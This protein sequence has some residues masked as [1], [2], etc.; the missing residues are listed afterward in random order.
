MKFGVIIH[1]G[2]HTLSGKEISWSMSNAKKYSS[3]NKKWDPKNWNPDNWGD[4][5]N[6]LGAKY[7]VWVA[8][9]HDGFCEW[10]TQTTNYN[11]MHTPY[12]KDVTAEIAKM[13]RKYGIDLGLYL[14]IMDAH[15]SGWNRIYPHGT[16]MPGF[17]QE[18][19][20]LA[21]YVKRQGLELIHKYHPFELWFDG[22]WLDGWR[23]SKYPKG[24]ATTFRNADSAILM[25][26]LGNYVNDYGSMEAKVG[27]Y[28]P[29]PWETVTSVSYPRYSWGWNLHFKSVPYLVQSFC[30]T[31]IGNGNYLL[32]FVPAPSGKIQEKQQKIAKKMGTWVHKNSTAIFGTRA[33]PYYPNKWGGSTHRG[34]EVY[35]FI[36]KEAPK[37]FYLPPIGTKVLSTRV[38]SGSKGIKVKQ[39]KEGGLTVIAPKNAK[40][41]KGVAVV[42]LRL[43]HAVNK[44]IEASNPKSPLHLDIKKAPK[45]IQNRGGKVSNQ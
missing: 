20:E 12:H 24:L 18:I 5:I 8:K 30:R 37:K 29:Y 34:N 32:A 6:E 2:P 26:R 19:P 25:T 38:I 11:V 27:A 39:N 45:P 17:P 21:N 10:N 16:K 15:F 13:C 31:I 1:W 23:S 41:A 28:S 14:S 36:L 42:A 35:L 3:W 4:I 44:M 7:L 33:G 22:G 40:D 9:H 43:K